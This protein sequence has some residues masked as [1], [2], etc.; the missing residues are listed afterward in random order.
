MSLAQARSLSLDGVTWIAL[1]DAV[2]ALGGTPER[3][4]L[5]TAR[6]LP[7]GHFRIH[8]LYGDG[9]EPT[10]EGMVTFKGLAMFLR[11]SPLPQRNGVADALLESSLE[12]L[13]LAGVKRPRQ[14]AEG[15][16]RWGVQPFRSALRGRWPSLTVTEVAGMLD[17]HTSG[18]ER[19]ITKASF[20]SVAVG[21]QLPSPTF[22]R[23]LQRVFQLPASELFTPEVLAA[24]HRKYGSSSTPTP[25][26]PP[27]RP[28][29]VEMPDFSSLR[30]PSGPILSAGGFDPDDVPPPDDPSWFTSSPTTP[31]S[32][33]S[34]PAAEP[35][36]R[37]KWLV[38]ADAAMDAAFAEVLSE[39]DDTVDYGD[40]QNDL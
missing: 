26:P 12:S 8:P 37:P 1:E 18:T 20:D 14:G 24:Y 17:Q 7:A 13:S 5:S 21:R 19:A 27:E 35:D 2:K 33:P 4:D 28:T 29:F 16:T 11:L 6:Q 9:P 3:A 32:P 39:P 15:P 36:D 30:A 25:A 10:Q 34:P 40:A 38:E 23:C 31:L 22:L